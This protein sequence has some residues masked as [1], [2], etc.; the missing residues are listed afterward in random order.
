MPGG[1]PI[2]R[3]TRSL[4]INL[5]SHPIHTENLINAPPDCGYTNAWPIS[6]HHRGDWWHLRVPDVVAS[7]AT[8]GLPVVHCGQDERPNA[9]HHPARPNAVGAMG[10]KPHRSFHRG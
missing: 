1:C 7:R 6:A 10:D 3:V 2:A 9:S 5:R 4:S 8:I